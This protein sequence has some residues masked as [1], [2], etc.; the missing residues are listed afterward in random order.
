MDGSSRKVGL[1][2]YDDRTKQLTPQHKLLCIMA[3]LVQS[4]PVYVPAYRHASDP[5]L[6]TNTFG[7][8]LFGLVLAQADEQ[9]E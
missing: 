4:A 1:L 8:S 6:A 3:G 5:S 2:L 9:G 7:G